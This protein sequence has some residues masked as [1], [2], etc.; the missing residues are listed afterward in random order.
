MQ[1]REIV[2]VRRS[3]SP[4][5]LTAFQKITVPDQYLFHVGIHSLIDTPAMWRGGIWHPVSQYDHVAPALGGDARINDSPGTTGEDRISE[6]RIPAADT[7]QI[8]AQMPCGAERLRV[9]G[10]RTVLAADGGFK[11]GRQRQGCYFQC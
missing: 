4:D 9:I 10:Q 5:L 11:T 8:A 2:S 3:H 1:M 6:I 7:V